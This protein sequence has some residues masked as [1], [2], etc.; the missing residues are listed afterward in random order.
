M[1]FPVKYTDL[2]GDEGYRASVAGTSTHPTT[3][4]DHC[5]PFHSRRNTEAGA[6]EKAGSH[7]GAAFKILALDLGWPGFKLGFK[8]PLY[9]NVEPGHR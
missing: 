8:L 4:T 7:V 1:F 2:V 3:P 6:S 9:V 5:L